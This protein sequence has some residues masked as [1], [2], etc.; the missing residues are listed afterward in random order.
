MPH[1]DTADVAHTQAT[2]HRILRRPG[3]A[4]RRSSPATLIAFPHDEPVDARDVALAWEELANRGNR[5]AGGEAISSLGI[6]LKQNPD[7]PA[8]LGAFGFE[9]QKHGQLDQARA[10]Y[11]HALRSDPLDRTV[12]TNLAVIEA[13]SGQAAGAVQLWRAAFDRAPYRSEIGIDL[14]V[15]LCS[16]G[17]YDESRRYLDRVLQFN[18]DSSIALSL[19]K[20]ESGRP[21]A[22]RF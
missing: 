18:P 16:S 7:D 8:L 11:Q 15:V 10:A 14:A 5:D 6:A 12:A 3:E 9:E 1:V 19:L 22:C 21:P 13:R 20:S 2:D 17:Q 4:G